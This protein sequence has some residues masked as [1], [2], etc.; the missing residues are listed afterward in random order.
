MLV[1][2]VK[3]SEKWASRIVMVHWWLFLPLSRWD[4]SK[5]M[6]PEEAHRHEWFAAAAAQTAASPGS[7]NAGPTAAATQQQQQ[8]VHPSPT[9]KC[10]EDYSDGIFSASS[11]S[12]TGSGLPS[13]T[14]TSTVDR[15]A[16]YQVFKGTKNKTPSSNPAPDEQKQEADDDSAMASQQRRSDG[17]SNLDD[18]GTFLPSI[19]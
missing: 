16:M 5:R 12:S 9:N 6:T 8:Q 4:P 3:T 17:N 14:A 7:A 15:S 2:K 19:L 13:A 1:F 11:S 10:P 18:S